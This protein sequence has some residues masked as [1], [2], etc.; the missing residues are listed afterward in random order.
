MVGLGTPN[1][2]HPRAGSC[3]I[4][5]Y[6][7]GFTQFRVSRNPWSQSFGV[8]GLLS[9]GGCSCLIV[10][11]RVG[12]PGGVPV[13]NAILVVVVG[14]VW[15]TGCFRV[16]VVLV[17]A[18]SL[19]VPAG[20]VAAQGGF[21]DL[22]EAGSHRAGVEGLAERGVL[23]GTLCA[24]E[25]F[26][27]GDLLARWVMA[28]WLVRVL[29]GTDPVGSG[30][31]FA[32]VGSDEWWAPYVERLA[33]LGVTTG[34]ATGPARYCP[35]DSVTRAQ[36]A[37][38]LTL[39][40]D[41]GAASSFGFVD[42]EG[43]THA[44]S[45]DALAAAGVT[46]GCA[47]GP[48]R[49]CP[50]DSVTRAQ[51]ATFLTR[52]VS[53][54]PL[55]VILASEEPRSVTGPF[56]AMISFSRSVTGFG[57]GDIRVVNGRAGGLAGS[58]SDYEITVI[59]AAEGTVV[60]R[61]PEGVAG[62]ASGTANQDSGL[63]V[64]TL[65][66]DGSRGGTGFDTWDRD[67]VAAAYRAEFEREPTDPG[68][69]GNVADC[70]AG[71]TSQ[72]FRDSIVQRANWYR[73]MAGLNTVTEDPS[74]S[75]AAQ[76]KALIILAEGRSSHDPTPDWACYTEV[77]LNGGENLY[78]GESGL[79][80]V[81][82]YIRDEGDNNLAVG[83][84]RQ[85]LSPFVDEIGT[86]N[87]YN[88]D[89][90]RS[91]NAM[92]FGYDYNSDATVREP[93]GF[94]AWPPAGY[95]PAETVWGRWSFLLPGADF[96]ETAVEVADNYGHIP[97][98]VIWRAGAVVW[99]VHGDNNSVQLPEPRHGDKCYTVTLSRVTV[100]GTAQT[101]FQY[102]TCVID[103][104]GESDKSY[105][106]M[107]PVWSPDSTQIA[108][109]G[110][111]GNWWTIN[112]DGTNQRFFSFGPLAWSP[113]STRIAYTSNGIWV[114]NTDGTNQ[115]QLTDTGHSPAWSPDST[116]IAYRVTTRTGWSFTSR[117]WV[118]DADGTNQQELTN[119]DSQAWSPPDGTRIAYTNNGIWVVNA[120]GTDPRQLTDTG[121]SPAWS[122]DGTRIAY[123]VVNR[124]NGIWVVNAD[125][126]DP[127]QLTDTGRSPAWSP[128]GTRIAYAVV[129]RGN[130]IWVV[131]AD[132]TGPQQ[133]TDTGFSPT[134]SP[135]GTRIAYNHVG[136][137]LW[138]VNADGTGP[139]QLTE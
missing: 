18:S 52:A 86:G 44:A 13:S 70:E 74:R 131:N 41:L 117:I 32:D 72:P 58:G 101:P 11:P 139:Q 26:C 105:N 6:S 76:R 7:A 38:F 103:P 3:R 14:I 100:D 45:I 121:R 93:R 50:A 127:R 122:P 80:S 118:V 88:A 137:H 102:A 116:R 47:T 96:S 85:I 75:A 92:H 60:V 39:A 24:P 17:L 62:D 108:Y 25:E 134:W 115:Q 54:G 89:R 66:S 56:Q 132:G 109:S 64:R 97:V 8:G 135:D 16:V 107:P 57:L 81:D 40:L 2:N 59:P 129:N 95:V 125:G 73:Q 22:G 126:T 133:L 42:T 10:Q 84:R 78:L 136:N 79:A 31:R 61:I 119:G 9:A 28:V 82:G 27:P 99:A 34:C 15:P 113:D 104:G 30:S 71:T 90:N 120:D 128:D 37:T 4:S 19:V 35:H 87:V 68:F 51:M 65:R 83:H 106:S 138:V 111:G 53:T 124:G 123:A 1:P 49:Y 20:S 33:E 36:M 91:A 112:A 21:S 55:S 63:L 23:E 43:N 77:P 5:H 46:A 69:T 114:A 29:D 48:A 130:G 67:A 12:P 94:V 110:G 98:K